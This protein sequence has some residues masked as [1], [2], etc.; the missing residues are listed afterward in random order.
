MTNKRL[1]E[2]LDQLGMIDDDSEKRCCVED[3]P[4]TTPAED[5]ENITSK[6]LIAV[7]NFVDDLFLTNDEATIKKFLVAAIFENNTDV[8]G[9]D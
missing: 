3:E 7:M 4:Y 9:A 5:F 1:Y 2:I 8:K 6:D